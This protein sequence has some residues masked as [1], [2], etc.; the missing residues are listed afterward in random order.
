[1]IRELITG[2]ALFIAPGFF[3]PLVAYPG[4]PVVAAPHI[5]VLVIILVA[6]YLTA[7]R[8]I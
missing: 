5:P 4:G 6:G 8:R 2:F 7:R 3:S 1:M